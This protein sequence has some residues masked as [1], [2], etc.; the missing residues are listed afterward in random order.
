MSL[1]MLSR[2]FYF[3]AIS[4]RPDILCS[5]FGV[6]AILATL[7]WIQTRKRRWLIAS[8]IAIGLGGLTHPFALAYAVQMAAWVFLSGRGRER[9]IAPLMLAAVS[10]LTASLW[11]VL[12]VQ[13]PE[14]FE[15]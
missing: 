1:F 4:A 3:P 9:V 8:G 11:L 6:M 2:W 12:I 15:I 14:I 5:A 10:L 13:A 7:S